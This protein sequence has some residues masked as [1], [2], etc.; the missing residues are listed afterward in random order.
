M[1]HKERSDRYDA[2]YGALYA[3]GKALYDRSFDVQGRLREER[4]REAG[5][6]FRAACRVKRWRDAAWVKWWDEK[7][8]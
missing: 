6:H 2:I 3:K 5:R 8:A 1:T 4:Q 7:F